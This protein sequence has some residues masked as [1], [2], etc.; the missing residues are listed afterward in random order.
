MKVAFIGLGIMGRH[1]ARN[2]MRHDDLTLSVFN[3]SPEPVEALVEAGARGANSAEEAVAEADIVFTMLAEPSVVEAVAFGEGGFVAAM[4]E[5]AL[6]VDCS[7]VNPSFSR[8]MATRAGGH[9]LRFVDAPVAGTKQPAEEA[10]LTFLVGGA[11]ED[12]EILRPLLDCMGQKIV[13]AGETGQG[14]AFKML[15]NA[16]LAQ[17]MLVYAETALLGENLGFSRDFLMD[18]LPNLPVSAPFLAGK[19]ELIRSGDYAAQFPLEWMHKDLQLLDLTAYEQNQ[20]LYLASLAK[21]LYG[22]AKAA[23]HGRDDFA[24]IH[25]YLANQADQG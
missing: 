24:A 23:G 17:S 19:A 1:M 15:V 8:A 5:G 2:L 3:R 12:V 18:T 13:H 16:Q 10:A 22:S 20:P 6:W 7:T 9:G 4:G 25:A 11:R 21:S 14:A